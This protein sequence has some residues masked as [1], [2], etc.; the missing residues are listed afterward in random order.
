MSKSAKPQPKPPL[1]IVTIPKDP[2][3]TNLHP[4]PFAAAQAPDPQLALQLIEDQKGQVIQL[5]HLLALL[6][7]SQIKKLPI[8]HLLILL[9]LLQYHPHPLRYRTIEETTALPRRTTQDAIKAL[10]RYIHTTKPKNAPAYHVSTN[11]YGLTDEGLQLTIKL[12]RL[13]LKP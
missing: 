9:T 8:H 1:Y 11:Y 6:R 12:L 10:P 2:D 7:D 5:P 4:S 13:I 3:E